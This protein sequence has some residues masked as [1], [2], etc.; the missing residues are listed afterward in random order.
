MERIKRSLPEE[1][2]E[3]LILNGTM[4]APK[5]CPGFILRGKPGHCFDASLINALLNQDKLRYVE[6]MAFMRTTGEWAP[7]AWVTDGLWA[8]DPTWRAYDNRRKTEV[9]VPTRYMGI[10]LDSQKAA[11]FVSE[12]EYQGIM[13]NAFHFPH[14]AK[15]VLPEN[16]PVVKWFQQMD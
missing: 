2:K 11:E 13:A 6:G 15:K 3:W 4:Y 12:T 5:V 1:V 16:F 14:E 8:F 7:H 9:P 10:E